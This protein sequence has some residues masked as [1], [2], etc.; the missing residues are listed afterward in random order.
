MRIWIIISSI[1][2]T[3]V[4]TSKSSWVRVK[5]NLEKTIKIIILFF[6]AFVMLATIIP[7]VINPIRRP[8]GM[9]RNYILRQTPLGTSIYDVITIVE[10]RDDWGEAYIDFEKG[11]LTSTSRRPTIEEQFSSYVIGE[12]TV[13]VNLGGFHAWYIVFG[14]PRV[15]TSARWGFDADGRLIEVFIRQGWSP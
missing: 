13:S 6:I 8:R 4:L 9:V 7:M 11:F 14:V 15:S 2:S 10:G 5:N 3:L 1:L 12:M